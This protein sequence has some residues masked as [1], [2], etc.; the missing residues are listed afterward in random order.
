MNGPLHAR[1]DNG[2]G[3]DLDHETWTRKL[4]D[5]HRRRGAARQNLAHR[6]SFHVDG[7]GAPSNVGI[8]QQFAVC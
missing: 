3:L 4:R 7:E 1:I 8:E 2:Y 5:I 6:A